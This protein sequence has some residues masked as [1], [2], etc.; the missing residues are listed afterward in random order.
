M[1]NMQKKID[2]NPF[3]IMDRVL[4]LFQHTQKIT[5]PLHWGNQTFRKVPSNIYI[6]NKRPLIFVLV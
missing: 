5:L 1:K 3:K 4:N 6:F 2:S